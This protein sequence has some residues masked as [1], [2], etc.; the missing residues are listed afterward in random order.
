[1]TTIE[2]FH[3]DP[4]PIAAAPTVPAQPIAAL[5]L[6]FPAV[7]A[8]LLVLMG[9][10][11]AAEISLGVQ[12]WSKA[13][14]PGVLTLMAFGGLQYPLVVDQGQWYR[15]LSAPLLHLDIF[16]ILIN[17]L[18]L[19]YAGRILETMIGR[20]WF[21]AVFVIG[22]IGGGLMSLALN[23]HNIVSVGASGAIMAVL[24]ATLVLG[25]HYEA[26]SERYGLQY[27]ALRLLV[28]SLIPLGT[29]SHASAVDY[30]AHFGGAIAGLVMAAILLAIWRK[31]DATPAL[32]PVA[33]VIVALGLFATGYSARANFDEYHVYN[34][35]RFLIPAAEIPKDFRTTIAKAPDLVKRYPRDPRARLYNA[36]ALVQVSDLAGAEK[37]MRIGLSEQDILRVLLTPASKKHFESYLA[38]ILFDEHRKDEAIEYAKAGCLSTS[39]SLH[40]NLIKLGLCETARS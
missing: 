10:I 9:L 13:F 2:S 12:P 35:Q 37:E 6:V 29:G 39:A 21:A 27:N 36:I 23:A 11:F 33:V 25:F 4:A 24:A 18:V 26:G 14:Q 38:L 19:C 17:G 7:T 8:A 16:H 30:G 22:G 3:G 5:T 32:R 40:P 1:M 34:L 28:P 31:R 20:M 15:L